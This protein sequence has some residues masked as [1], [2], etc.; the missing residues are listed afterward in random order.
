MSI[1]SMSFSYKISDIIHSKKL[2]TFTKSDLKVSD[3]SN[4]VIANLPITALLGVLH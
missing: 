1:K 2:E 4:F 3:R